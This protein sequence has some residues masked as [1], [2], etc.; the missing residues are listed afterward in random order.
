MISGPEGHVYHSEKLDLELENIWGLFPS[1][2][3]QVYTGMD[4]TE[5]WIHIKKE[6][7]LH[8]PLGDHGQM[9]QNQTCLAPSHPSPCAL[10]PRGGTQDEQQQ[11]MNPA[12]VY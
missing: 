3:G 1:E 4:V 12:L 9:L 8:V 11:M 5:L 2:H 7:P 6:Q 10:N